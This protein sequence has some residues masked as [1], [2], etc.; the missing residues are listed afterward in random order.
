MI[1]AEEN[2]MSGACSA[3]DKTRNLYRIS[4]G[5]LLPFVEDVCSVNLMW[6]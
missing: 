5:R 6:K 4:V 2:E 3:Y 1:T